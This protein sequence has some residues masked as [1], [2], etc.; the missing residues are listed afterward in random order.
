MCTT[1]CVRITKKT[2]VRP[3]ANTTWGKQTR[4]KKNVAVLKN[5]QPKMPAISDFNFFSVVNIFAIKLCL[6][7]TIFLCARFY[8]ILGY[9]RT[10]R[11]GKVDILC[12]LRSCIFICRAFLRWNLMNLKLPANRN[13]LLKM[14]VL[15]PA[16]L[17]LLKSTFLRQ[18]S[19]LWPSGTKIGEAIWSVD[20]S[21][22]VKVVK[23]HK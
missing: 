8:L 5:L 14:Q 15:F 17:W 18:M 16:L 12:V 21:K 23:M 7:L 9:K 2:P 11:Q 10:K 22:K 13:T 1:L 3:T 20:Y 6:Y 4:F 19:S